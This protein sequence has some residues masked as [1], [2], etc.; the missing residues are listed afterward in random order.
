VILI[1]L[2]PLLPE[3]DAAALISDCVWDGG[4]G[5]MTAYFVLS[6]LPQIACPKR[7]A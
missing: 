3:S 6:R 5:D 7:H 4:R 1:F 2:C